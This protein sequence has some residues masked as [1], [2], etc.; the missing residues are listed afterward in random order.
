M[1]DEG[2]FFTVIGLCFLLAVAICIKN[3][4]ESQAI[5]SFNAADYQAEQELQNAA[6]SAL[7]EA[8]EKIQKVNSEGTPEELEQ[9]IPTPPKFYASRAE[10]QFHILTVTKN[11]SRLKNIEVKVYGERSNI[12]TEH[13]KESTATISIQDKEGVILISV[14]SANSRFDDKKIY[15]RSLA[16]I[17]LADDAPKKIFYLNSL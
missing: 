2:G 15:R 13:G 4:Q 7:I 12:H 14:A 17:Y 6:D 11:Y 16:F 5:Y 9:I 8:A 3:I 10:R 1:K